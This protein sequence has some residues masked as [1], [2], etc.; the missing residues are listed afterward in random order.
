MTENPLDSIQSEM[1]FESEETYTEQEEDT[2]KSTLDEYFDEN[3]IYANMVQEHL[4]SLAERGSMV[5]T[6]N[7]YLKVLDIANH[8]VNMFRD[9][10]EDD[11][12]DKWEKEVRKMR[13]TVDDERLEQD[14][15]A[16]F[17]LQVDPQDQSEGSIDYIPVGYVETA[18]K[19]HGRMMR[20]FCLR[21]LSG[22]DV[23]SE[24]TS[25]GRGGR[26]RL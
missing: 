21:V 13:S 3:D 18:V 25:R 2:R 6:A 23:T 5:T 12:A 17:E 10:G 9:K 22:T 20:G 8:M 19:R 14:L 15:N 24:G 11:L 16:S 1:A 7:I 26:R 4:E